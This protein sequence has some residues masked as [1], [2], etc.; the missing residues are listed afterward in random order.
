LVRVK[1]IVRP[2][3]DVRATRTGSR[4]SLF[5]WKMWCAM[6]EI[7]A[8]LVS[9]LCVTGLVRKRLTITLTPASRVA[10]NNIR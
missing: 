7:G 8:W 10:E 3:A 1:T 2:G 5:T 6:V 9:A 4:A